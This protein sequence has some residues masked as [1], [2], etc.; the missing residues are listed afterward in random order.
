M[1]LCGL[2]WRCSQGV[3]RSCTTCKGW[4]NCS[5]KIALCYLDHLAPHRLH[6]ASPTQWKPALNDHPQPY[7]AA[8]DSF[9]A[10]QWALP[11]QARG[12]FK[13]CIEALGWGPSTEGKQEK[14]APGVQKHSQTG[15]RCCCWGIPGV[16]NSDLFPT[17]H[18]RPKACCLIHACP[19]TGE[20]TPKQ[21]RSHQQTHAPEEKRKAEA[22]YRHLW[23]CWIWYYKT[24]R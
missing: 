13:E 18:S 11:V 7:N 6:Q 21:G 17:L 2:S 20:Q 19:D 8:K 4:A 14:Q 24:L 3:W 16:A 15:V 1:L 5:M 10:S 9:A 23:S 12:F 22:P